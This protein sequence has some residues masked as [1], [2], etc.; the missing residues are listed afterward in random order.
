MAT[1][2]QVDRV[3]EDFKR[4]DEGMEEVLW[5]PAD[6][7]VRLVVVSNTA[8]ASGAVVETFRFPADPDDPADS[9]KEVGLIRPED[10]D[11]VVYP[12]GW[13]RESAEVI[14]IHEAHAA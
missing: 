1:R 2:E 10:V 8:P 14:P 9:P 13:N 11:R 6:N 12:S 5:F 7:S 3:I 4:V